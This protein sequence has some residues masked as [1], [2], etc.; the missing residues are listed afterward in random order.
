MK[1]PWLR[2]SKSLRSS[3]KIKNIARSSSRFGQKIKYIERYSN[4]LE[5]SEDSSSLMPTHMESN[6]EET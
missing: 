3:H 4:S 2:F 1:C 6:I 5:T